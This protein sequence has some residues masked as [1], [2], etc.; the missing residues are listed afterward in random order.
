MNIDAMEK[1]HVYNEDCC[2][3]LDLHNDSGLAFK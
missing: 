3:D 1:I 2:D